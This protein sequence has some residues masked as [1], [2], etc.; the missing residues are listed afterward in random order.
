MVIVQAILTQYEVARARRWDRTYWAVDLHGTLIRPNYRDDELS[1]DFYAH[2]VE[3]MRL[4][5]RRSDVIL[6]MYT[7][8]WPREVR[9]YIEKFQTNGICFD[10][11]NKNPEVKSEGYGDYREK[12]YFNVLLDDKAGFDPELHWEEILDLLPRLP[13]LSASV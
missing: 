5:T 13:V 10:F 6:I 1:T 7:C 11:V 8:S 12:P 3:T 9:R 4:L 2:A